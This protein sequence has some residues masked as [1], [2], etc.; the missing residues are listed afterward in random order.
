MVFAYRITKATNTRSECAILT[1]FARQQ[2]LRET[3]LNI[4]FIRSLP[5][6]LTF[7]RNMLTSFH[8]VK[9]AVAGCSETSVRSYQTTRFHTRER[10]LGPKIKKIH[11][12]LSEKTG[13]VVAQ[14]VE[15]LSYMPEG[16]GFD[17]RWC[18]LDFSLT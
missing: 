6:L 9:T 11:Q 15:A 2:W 7:L 18:K 8:T 16:R 14:L 12:A 3:R 4:T 13:H 17:S 10:N 1:D 5:A